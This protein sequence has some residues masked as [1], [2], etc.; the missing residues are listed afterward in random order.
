[1]RIHGFGLSGPEATLLRGP[2][3]PAARQ[4]VRRELGPGSRILS[5]RARSGGTS[6]A[7]HVVTVEE[8]AG[9]RRRLILRRYV[10][11]DWLERE[12]DLAEHEAR[13][14]QLLERSSVA[15]PRPVAVDPR[16]DRCDVPAVL[17]T[18][19]PGRVRWSPRD[20][21]AYLAQLVDQLLPI[22]A[23]SI[24]ASVPIRDF[25]PYYQGC[26][27]EPPA[28]TTCRDAWA[29]A[30]EVH[31]GPPPVQE[32]GFIHRDYH[33]GNVLWSGESLTGIVDWASASR[34]SPE[35]DVAHCRVNLAHHLG[36]DT[37][38]RFLAI[39]GDRTGRS[40]FHPY[41]DLMTA[42]G[43]LDDADAHWRPALDEVVMRATARL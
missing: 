32:R 34:G 17:M 40:A 23:V 25:S 35:A 30:F 27:L 8:A 41:W 42:V 16:G 39:Y 2:P 5:V 26:S 3:P 19:L 10:R 1:M 7:V 31:A 29:R 21:D 36:Y 38:E 20:L 11:A 37:A 9:A 4:W 28:G 18:G 24:P 6:S 43:M 12:P 14:L 13:V 33:P 15:A 22:H